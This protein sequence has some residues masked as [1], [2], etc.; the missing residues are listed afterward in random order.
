MRQRFET[1]LQ[2]HWRRRDWLSQL[3]L[4]VSWLVASVLAW[5]TGRAR[6]LAPPLAP[7]PVVVIGNI[8][9]GGTGKTPVVLALC[10]ALAARGWHPGVVS[11]GYGARIGPTAH[12]SHDGIDARR[13][14]DEPALIAR[15]TGVP[16]AVH[17]KRPH[18]ISA[19]LAAHP[20]VDV[21]LS[22][23]GL[24]HH[25]MRRDLEI[26]V[27]DTRG[28]GNGRL[29]PAGPLREPATRL[30]QADWLIHHGTPPPAGAIGMVLRPVRVENPASGRILGWDD[31]LREHAHTPCSAAAAI[32]QPARFFDMLRAAGVPLGKVLPLPDH[33]DFQDRPLRNLPP[34][35]ILVTAKDAMK[36]AAQDDP[37]I[38]VVHVEAVFSRPDWIDALDLRLR[39]IREQRCHKSTVS[40]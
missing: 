26:I 28:T 1:W 36:C 4:P 30:A 37:R 39:Q 29:L 5:R 7:V 25:G 23:D 6:R 3:L 27:Q 20:Q 31:W 15:E 34:G 2:G 18:A 40:N 21:I 35:P 19:L 11:R 10:R 32:G 24:Q 12:L 8:L 38:W 16:V 9:V 33:H 22:D 14:G 17:P 13:L